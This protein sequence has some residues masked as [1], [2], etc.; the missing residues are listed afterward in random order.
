[1]A[2]MRGDAT[3]TDDY[4]ADWRSSDWQPSEMDAEQLADSLAAE[5]EAEYTQ[6]R[7]KNLVLSQG[8]ET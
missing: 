1:M 3:S 7:L 6:E 2:A 5:I 8:F 4:L